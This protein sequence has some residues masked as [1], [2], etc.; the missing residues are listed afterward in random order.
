[1]VGS[2]CLTDILITTKIT[3][4]PASLGENVFDTPVVTLGASA[5]EQVVFHNTPCRELFGSDTLNRTK[6]RKD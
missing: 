5:N 3:P 1:M 2:H 6:P 4:Y